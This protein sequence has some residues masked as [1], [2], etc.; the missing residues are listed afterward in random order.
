MAAGST[1]FFLNLLQLVPAKP[2]DGGFVIQAVS[3]W[4]LIPGT[5]LLFFLAM[6]F[7]SI[8]LLI[9]AVISVISLARQF[10][11]HR[12]A[13]T[14]P[15]PER[16][17]TAM[18]AFDPTYSAG[19][20][21]SERSEIIGVPAASLASPSTDA[22]PINSPI[23]SSDQM[24]PASIPQRFIIAGAYLG[25]AGMLAYLYWLSTNELVSFMP[26]RH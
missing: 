20:S 16:N 17:L 26:H 5:A 1:G 24:K 23:I 11:H 4:L 14:L 22:V 12:P 9:I 8:L 18:R 2:L 21:A 10:L 7:Q 3:R 15:A 25:L 13:E 19:A 6:R